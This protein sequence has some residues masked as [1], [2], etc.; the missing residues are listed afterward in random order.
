MLKVRGDWLLATPLIIILVLMLAPFYT[1]VTKHDWLLHAA[2][3]HQ[4][5][6]AIL[7]G[8]AVCP[9]DKLRIKNLAFLIVLAAIFITVFNI[10]FGI[11]YD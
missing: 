8:W 1:P 10:L 4:F 7:F 2:H 11:F 3:D 6:L 9:M 5:L